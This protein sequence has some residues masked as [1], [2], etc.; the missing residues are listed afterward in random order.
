M[1]KTPFP[2]RGSLGFSGHEARTM[3]RGIWSAALVRGLG[4]SCSSGPG[5]RRSPHQVWKVVGIWVSPSER[6]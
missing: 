1:E 3:S 5:N 6:G 2:R 4:S